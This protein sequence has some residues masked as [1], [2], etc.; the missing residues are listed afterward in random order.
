MDASRVRLKHLKRDPR[1]ALT[2]FSADDWYSH[3]SLSGSVTDMRHDVGLADI[4]EMS[5]RFDAHPYPDRDGDRWTAEVAVN[6][7]HAWGA[8]AD[9]G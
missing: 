9:R 3:V 5:K 8:L 1:V 6:R 2:I 7:W 4:D